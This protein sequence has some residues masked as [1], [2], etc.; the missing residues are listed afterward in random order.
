[1]IFHLVMN[2]NVFTARQAP[3]RSDTAVMFI[4]YHIIILSGNDVSMMSD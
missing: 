3:D 2:L 1:M 4:F